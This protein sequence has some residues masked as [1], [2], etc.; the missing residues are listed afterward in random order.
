MGYH[1]PQD[2]IN[3]NYLFKDP[4]SKNNQIQLNIASQM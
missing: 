3:F 4:I 1:P 2:L